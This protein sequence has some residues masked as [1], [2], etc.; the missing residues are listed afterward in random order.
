MSTYERVFGRM[1]KQVVGHC[2]AV[3]HKQQ[4]EIIKILLMFSAI[5]LNDAIDRMEKMK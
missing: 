4:E 5:C 2:P 1:K 3:N